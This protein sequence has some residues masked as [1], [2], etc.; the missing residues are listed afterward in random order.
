[1]ECCTY[2]PQQVCGASLSGMFRRSA[3]LAIPHRKSFATIPSGAPSA[4][5]TRIATFRCRTNRS[6][7]CPR[8][9]TFTTD[10]WLPTRTTG[11]KTGLCFARFAFLIQ[12]SPRQT[13]PKK[14]PKRKVREFRP[15]LW[16]LVFFLRR[17]STIHIELLFRNAPSKSSWTDL[18]LVWF[19]GA[20]PDWWFAGRWHRTIRIRIWIARY[21]ATKA[22]RTTTY[23]EETLRGWASKGKGPEP[24]FR[25]TQKEVGRRSSITF[26]GIVQK[27]FSSK[28]V[29]R[30]FEAFLTQ[31]WRISEAFWTF[32]FSQ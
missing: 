5:C 4:L 23:S 14:E 29:P 10:S 8:L 11:R 3:S 22:N 31:F 15:F 27:V 9:G 19:A 18:S 7:N 28:G 30:I 12:E 1:M 13:K 2:F 32:L 24:S 20:T 6:V 17:T 21:N 25:V 26:F 16:I